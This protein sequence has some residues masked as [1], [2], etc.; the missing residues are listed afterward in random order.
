MNKYYIKYISL[1]PVFVLIQILILNE[2]LFSSYI[3][4]YLYLILIIRF[5]LKGSK[6]FF[7]FY[8][9]ILGF[10][11]DIFS[12]TL[13]FHS[14][15]TVFIAFIRKAISKITIPHNIIGDNEYITLKKI[16]SKSFITFSLFIILAHNT[17]LFL[18]EH[19]AIN[20]SISSKI[21]A[22]SLVT[23]VLILILEIYNF[24]KK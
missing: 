3:N 4:P 17:S 1:L 9:F 13:G 19:L 21:L 16:G 24:E 2:I 15:A 7:L 10:F 6:W 14:T 11:I 8:A 23:L 22:S 12:G 5:P 18:L 20:L